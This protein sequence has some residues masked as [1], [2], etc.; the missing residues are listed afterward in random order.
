M[1]AFDDFLAAPAAERCWLL[2]LEAFPLAPVS[3]SSLRGYYAGPG[4]S[5]LGYSAGP[6]GSEGALTT[7]FYSERGYISKIYDANGVAGGDPASEVW[8]DGRLQPGIRVERRIIGRDGIGGLA[9]V[10]AEGA[11]VNRDGG[12]DLLTHNYSL[13]GR[14]ARLYVGRPTDK[15]A[16]FGLVVSG[17]SDRVWSALDSVRIGFSDGL[18]RLD[19]NVNTTVYAGTGTSATVEGGADLKGKYKPKAYGKSFNVSAPLADSALLIYQVHDGACNDVTAAYDRGIALAKG[20]DYVSLA[21]MTASA[22]AAGQ[23]RVW[24]A[25]GMFRLGAT[26]AGTVTADIEGDATGGYIAKTGEIVDRILTAQAE[27]AAGDINAASFTALDARAPAPVGIWIGTEGRLIADCID[28]LLAGV[29]AFGGFS[30]LGAFS[31]GLVDAPTGA[32]ADT[33]TQE[34]IFTIERLPLPAA[35]DPI[36][37]RARVG[38]QRNYT[39]QSDLA[40]G[41]SVA[42]RTFSGERVRFEPAEDASLRSRH[43]LAGELEA[44]AL[45]RDQVDAAA[46]AARLLDLWGVERGMF[47]VTLPPRALTRDLGDVV[48]LEHPR[49][50]WAAGVAARILGHAFSGDR[51]EL[52]VLV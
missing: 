11:L 31:V 35:V 7:L 33:F 6:G 10:F 5:Q 22:P 52:T 30:R 21:D 50:G 43:K 49:Y 17:I 27:F 14:A 1:N 28:E 20:A 51:V 29:G 25:G 12:I 40:A 18:A 37:W 46:E 19:R 41:V 39:V 13:A 47:R 8:Y 4:Y 3:A 34:D 16:D 38:W 26:P 32:I 44:N 2:E 42:R 45:Y 36:V 15:R 9:R 23:Y 48:T 24:K